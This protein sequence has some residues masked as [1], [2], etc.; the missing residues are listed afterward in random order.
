MRS[1]QMLVRCGLLAV[2]VMSASVSA[3]PSPGQLW[4]GLAGG[5]AS[6]EV[7]QVTQVAPPEIDYWAVD[8]YGRL[9]I[10]L[11]CPTPGAVIRYTANGSYPQYYSPLYV[12]P[13]IITGN[14][15]LKVRAFKD[16][17]YG[18][19]KVLVIKISCY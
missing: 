14:G 18:G 8:W 11:R 10:W 6:M 3:A 15:T 2:L 16:G 17:V 4:S 7:T 13:L 1:K 19:S 5:I 9:W 12:G